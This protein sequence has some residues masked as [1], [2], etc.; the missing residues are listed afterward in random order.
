[1]AEE[2]T[3]ERMV[4]LAREVATSLGKATITTS[5]FLRGSGLSAWQIQKHFDGFRDLCSQAGLEPHLQNVRLDDAEIFRAMMD[6]FTALGGVTSRQRFD[7]EFRYSVDVFKK[8]GWSWEG[9]KSRFRD[10]LDA[11]QVPFPYRDQLVQAN[12]PPVAEPMLEAVASQPTVWSRRGGPQFGD[13]LNFRGLQHAP[14]NE[15]GVVF[16]FGMIAH[17]IGFRV[18]A[19]QTGFPDCEAKRHVGHGRWQRIRIEFEFLARS[20]RD[21]GHDPNGCDL[22]ICWENNW[23]EAPVEVLALSGVIGTLTP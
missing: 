1:M 7:R 15:Q 9:T 11:E 20:F 10:W 16:L 19:V 4:E 18:E 21:H 13:F 2:I 6:A 5:D 23:P 22:I 17:E 8:R 14:I 3:K 12:R